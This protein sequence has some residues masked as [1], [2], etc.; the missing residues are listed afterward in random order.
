[1]VRRLR[2]NSG[3]IHLRFGEPLSLRKALGPPTAGADAEPDERSID[4]QK[5]A[6]EV[7]VRINRV[8]PITPTSLV[9][10]AL[11]GS[12]GQ[13]LSVGQLITSLHNLVAYVRRRRLPTTVELELDTPDGVRRAVEPLVESGVV[14]AFTE[15]A[16]PVYYIAPDALLTAAYYRNTVIHF[17]VNGAIAELALLKAA[18]AGVTDPLAAL[19]DEAFRLRDMFKFEFFFADKDVFRE[20]LREEIALHDPQWEAQ[21]AAGGESIYALLRRFRPFSAHRTLRPFVEAYQVVADVLERHDPAAPLDESAFLVACL[22][23]GKQYQLQRRIRSPES[24]SK[25]LFGTALS[26]ARNRRL[27]DPAGDD[28]A[29]RRSEFARDIRDVIRRVDA[30]DALVASRR[31]GLIE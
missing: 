29:A 2:R 31:A 23:S 3:D 24:V 26:L 5:V 27:L 16:E 30:V 20:E 25:V 10:L 1:V 28:L 14:T 17:F 21:V 4:T 11:L 6:F 9:T 22:A 12:G 18:E 7:A 19:W 15:G 13:A 8:T